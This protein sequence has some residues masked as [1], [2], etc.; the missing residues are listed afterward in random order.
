MIRR[1]DNFRVS[2]SLIEVT[3]PQSMSTPGSVG[4]PNCTNHQVQETEKEMCRVPYQVSRLCVISDYFLRFASGCPTAPGGLRQHET[5][6]R[7]GF[8][9]L[10][11]LNTGN[12]PDDQG[13]LSNLQ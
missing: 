10:Q 7:G 8:V 13:P 3:S 4:K 11:V 2:I 6:A 12:F 1:L 9:R 5:A